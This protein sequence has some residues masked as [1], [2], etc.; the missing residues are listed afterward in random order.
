MSEIKRQTR[1]KYT[2]FMEGKHYLNIQS[3]TAQQEK[4]FL[5]QEKKREPRK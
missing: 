1:S 2:A 5:P 3:P 4:P